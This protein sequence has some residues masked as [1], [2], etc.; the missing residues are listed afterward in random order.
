MS[1]GTNQTDPNLVIGSSR[2][3]FRLPSW[4]NRWPQPGSLHIYRSKTRQQKLPAE[5]TAI[6]K[7]ERGFGVSVVSKWME[8]LNSI[9]MVSRLDGEN[10]TARVIESNCAQDD[11]S[12][13]LEEGKL[14]NGFCPV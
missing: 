12:S 11:L 1:V 7:P 10:G 8:G 4:E 9:D 14:T 13:G 5:C 6:C 2:L 3:T